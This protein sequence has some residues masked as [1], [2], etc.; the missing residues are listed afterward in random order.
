MKIGMITIG[1]SPRKDVTREIEDI[2]GG[3][4]TVERG[5][6]DDLT[7][8]QIGRLKPKEGEPFLVTLLRNGISVKVSKGKTVNLIQKRI[9][10]LEKEH[11][12]LIALLCT[13]AF[14][15]FKSEKLII[16][17]GKL[18]HMLVQG[19]ITK[20]KKIGVVVPSFGQIE[21]VKEKWKLLNPVITVA[22]PY[23]N[24]EKIN[25]A[26]EELQAENVDL[27][28]LDCIGYTEKMKQK[29]K[30]AT[31]KPVILPRTFLARVLRELC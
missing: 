30:E 17:P 14:P 5:C 23:D 22:S 12:N 19:I 13:G 28:V 24:L 21:Q 10:E 2:L 20:G 7:K 26:A 1:Q 29:V 4:E 9:R 25:E 8:E 6:L 16:E 3:V 31:G 18:I 11:V 15:N 27:T